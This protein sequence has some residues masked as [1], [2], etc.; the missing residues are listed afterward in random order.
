MDLVIKRQDSYSR[1]QLLLRTFF[2]W[3]YIAIPHFF[4]LCFVAIWS[5]I[6]SFLAF[7]AILFTGKYPAGWYEFQVK[8]MSW[9]A[10][11]TASL[12]N[13]TDAYPAF[14]PRGSSEVAFVKAARP[15]KISRGKT[16][17]RTLF[18]FIYVMIPHG[19]C[20]YFR[21]IASGFVMLVAWFAVLFSGKYP[22]SMHGFNVGTIRWSY[23]LSFYVMN[24]TDDYPPFSGK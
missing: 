2:G 19:F 10:R 13:L 22:E 6:L 1:G 12:Y 20:L 3:L 17:L 14:L 5:A 4:L 21:L 11:L 8:L 23:R 16:I 9:G 24:M 7:W 15:E 18:G